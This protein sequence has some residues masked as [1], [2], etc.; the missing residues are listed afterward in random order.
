[1][2]SEPFTYTLGDGDPL[3]VAARE[4]HD[5][6]YQVL[7]L[8]IGYRVDVKRTLTNDI[9]ALRDRKDKMLEDEKLKRHPGAR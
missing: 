1:M 9:R 3:I 8:A 5:L 4:G 7:S 2:Q 6:D